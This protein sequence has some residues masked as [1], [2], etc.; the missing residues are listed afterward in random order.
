MENKIIKTIPIN[1]VNDTLFFIPHL[2]L[3]DQ[4]VNNGLVNIFI[5]KFS[6]VV[7]VV[8]ENQLGSLL[9]AYE[10]IDELNKLANEN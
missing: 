10:L 6:N 9:S 2:G 1:K 8:K 4:I 7:L 3:G 5:E